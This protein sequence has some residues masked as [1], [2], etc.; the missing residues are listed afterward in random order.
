MQANPGDKIVFRSDYRLFEGT[1]KE[2]FPPLE[3]DDYCNEEC[4]RVALASG[5][6]AIVYPDEIIEVI[7]CSS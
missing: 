1:V 7:P 6:I 3:S 4:F 5:D 2:Y